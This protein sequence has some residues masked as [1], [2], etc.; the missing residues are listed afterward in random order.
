MPEIVIRAAKVQYACTVCFQ[1]VWRHFAIENR[2]FVQQTILC[3]GET[4]PHEPAQMAQVHGS[5]TEVPSGK[6]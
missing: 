3:L 6:P 5:F 2:T 4:Q 1:R